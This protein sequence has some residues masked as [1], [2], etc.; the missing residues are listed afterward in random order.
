MGTEQF[1]DGIDHFDRAEHAQLDR[2]YRGVGQ[3]GVGLGQ[4]PLAVEHAEV[5]NVDGILHGQG[6]HR[7]CGV[8]ALGDQGFD[9]C[10]QAGAATG[11][12]AGET[13]DNGAGAVGIHGR[14]AYHQT[15]LGGS[16]DKRVLLI[17]RS[18]C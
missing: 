16:S 9:I 17:D 8:T 18:G 4:H 14:R 3:Y 7:R 10:L 13:E 12:V 1:G 15:C 6:G 11:V 2:S 5:G